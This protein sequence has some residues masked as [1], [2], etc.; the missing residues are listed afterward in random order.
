MLP[1]RYSLRNVLVRRASAS[2][3][4]LG[5]GLTVAVFAGVIAL[6]DGFESVYTVGGDPDVA[7][8]LRPGAGSEGESGIPREQA[9]ILV[10]ERPEI[11]R[12][13]QGRPL[14]AMETFL[15]VYMEMIDGGLTNVPLRGIQPMSIE[16]MGDHVQLAEGRWLEFGTDEVVVGKPLTARMKGA[17]VGDTITLNL[18]PFKVV[19]VFEHDGS[20]AGEVWGDV[21]R[22]MEAL[23]RPFFQRVVAR[24]KP[25]TDFEALA[26]QLA[27]DVR[28]P[29]KVQ[30]ETAY[31]SAQTG[32]LG[33]ALQFLAGFLT[34]I[35]GASAVLGATNTMLASVASRTH[36]IGVLL[37]VG[38]GRASIFFTFL[39][40][41]ALM[42]LL[43]GVVGVL[44]VL[45][46]DG[47]GTGMMNFQTFTDVSFAF[48]VT[49]VSVA[50]SF[51]L[52]FVL[53]LVGGALP[54][55]RA[56]RQRPVEA[57]RAL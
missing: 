18:T 28:T 4:V 10:K 24:V 55:W 56:S 54:A 37:A 41:A 7:I 46:F 23:D 17:T 19:G 45:P 25:G 39:F 20:Q 31:L 14:A 27:N 44:L 32:A 16:L 51:T 40:E 8:Y 5:I 6:R 49:P 42:G 35:M 50:I 48:R 53:G 57:L 38:Y 29:M 52:A 12:D 34:L 13:A 15:A 9:E 26:K 43:G 33:G 47:L 11:A 22:M 30:S 1:L 2:L 21:E 36:E 3:T